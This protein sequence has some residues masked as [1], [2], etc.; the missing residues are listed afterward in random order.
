MTECDSA[1]AVDPY[2]DMSELTPTDAM[3]VSDDPVLHLL[4][5]FGNDTPPDNS[6]GMVISQLAVTVI[7]TE[8]IRIC[9]QGIRKV[10]VSSDGAIL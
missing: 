8:L 7:D 5:S 1:V 4:P 3:G 6:H 9:N 2:L 10:H